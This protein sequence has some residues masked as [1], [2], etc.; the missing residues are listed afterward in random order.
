MNTRTLI[1]TLAGLLAVF[2]LIA[3]TPK[4]ILLPKGIALP[5]EKTL[6]AISSD[7]V[8]IYHHSSPP[9]SF[10]TLGRLSIE[11]GYNPANQDTKT[12]LFQKIKSLAASL[13]ANG[14]IVTLMIPTTMLRPMIVF[15]GIA[16]RTTAKK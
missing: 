1:C 4:Q 3:L 7:Q 5:A 9:S 6:P 14:V 11:E 15:R 8:T 13:G 12:E 16:I 2:I 10:I